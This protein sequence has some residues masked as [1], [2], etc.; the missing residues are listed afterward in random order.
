[1]SLV[2]QRVIG[3]TSKSEADIAFIG[4]NLVCY[5]ALSYL[6]FY[7]FLTHRQVLL[8][9]NI[10]PQKA[11]KALCFEN[12]RLYASESNTKQGEIHV[13]AVSQGD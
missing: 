11:Y 1:M 5:C 8:L 6:V 3:S 13:Y 12:G 10:N 7:N 4:K 2:L 9:Q